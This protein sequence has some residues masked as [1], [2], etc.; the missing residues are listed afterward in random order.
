MP[1][2]IP[3]VT[4]RDAEAARAAA[5]RVV[6]VH[7]ALSGFLR[8]GLTLAEIDGFVAAT[9]QDLGSKSCFYRYGPGRMPPFPSHSC[10]SVN[11][12]IVHG[13]VADLERPLERGDL[14]SI[15]I[16]VSY[17]GWMGDAA[18][19][20]SFGP[21]SADA[22][23]LMEAGR[24]SLRRGIAALVPGRP[25]MVWAEAVQGYVEGEC[26]L[27]LARGLGGHGYGRRLHAP[28]FVSNIVPKGPPVFDEWPE[29]ATPI[30]PGTLVALEPMI[31]LGTGRTRQADRQW[32]IYTADGSLA[33]HYE[34][35]VL[36]TE[37]GPEVLTAGLEDIPDIIGG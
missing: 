9:L 10:L 11:D 15:D 21:P 18:W 28:P 17:R 29:G 12:C 2:A 33:V 14:L 4:G 35:D 37:D 6:D 31:A 20:Y 26:G 19:T 25:W 3:T 23:R 7:R 8:E 22:A 13:R 16:G 24:E 1:T 30:T 32:P 5:A 36:I 34:H 27:H